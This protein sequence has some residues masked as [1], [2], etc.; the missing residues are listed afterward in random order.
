MEHHTF[1]AADIA[2]GLMDDEAE[3]DKAMDEDVTIQSGE[4]V[5]KLFLF[6]SPLLSPQCS[7]QI[8]ANSQREAV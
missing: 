3:L 6:N 7:S 2:M 1:H 5:R 8:L 4:N